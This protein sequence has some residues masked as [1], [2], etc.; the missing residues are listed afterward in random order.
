MVKFFYI[1]DELEKPTSVR[2]A[3][4]MEKNQNYEIDSKEVDIIIDSGADAPIFPASMFHCGEAHDGEPLAL[5]DAQ[6]RQIPVLGQK[7]ISVLLEDAGGLEIELRDSVVFSNEI[8]QPILS[9]GRLMNAGWSICAESRSLKN[10]CY[11]IPTEFQ[12]NSLV[13]KGHVR[14][15]E[16]IPKAVR[17]VR[18]E[19]TPGL[20][21]YINSA[22]GWNKEG[23]RWVGIHLSAH[24]QDPLFVPNIDYTV[25]WHRTTLVKKDQGW[26]MVEFCEKVSE[27]A[28]ASHAIEETEG[29]TTVVTFLTDG[30]E[31]V[32]LMGFMVEGD[33][34]RDQLEAM[35]REIQPFL[36]IPEDVELERQEAEEGLQHGVQAPAGEVQG[37]DDRGALQPVAHDGQAQQPM[38]LQLPQEGQI[39]VGEVVPPQI[40]VDGKVLTAGS[41]LATLRAACGFYGVSRSGSKIKCYHR[42]CQHQKALELLLAQQAIAQAQGQVERHPNAQTLVRPPSAQEQELHALTHTPYAPWCSACIKHRARPD[43]HRRTGEAHNTPIPVIS[44]DFCVTKK[45]DGLDPNPEGAQDDALW[46]VLTDSQTGCLSAIPIQAKNQFNYMTHEVLSFVQGLGYAE[47]GFY[48]DNEPTIRQILKTIIT[49]R[50]ALGLKTRIFTTKVKDSAGNALVEN[51]IQRIRQL[52]CTLMEDVSEKTGLTFPCDHPLWSWAG[53][54]AAWCLNRYQVSKAL[55]TFEVTHGK[56]YSGKVAGFGEPVYGYC[57]ARGKADAKWRVGL[58]LGKTEA[59]D[60]WIIGDGVDVM[61]TRSIR[62]IDQPWTN[63]LAYFSGLQTHSFVYQTNFGG[64]IVPTKR[65][66]TPQRQEGR[67][68][69]KLSEIEKRFAD[70]EATL[71]MAYARSREGRLEAQREVQEAL[72]SLPEHAAVQ[73]QVHGQPPEVPQALPAGQELQVPPGAPSQSSNADLLAQPSSPRTSVPRTLQAGDAEQEE[74]SSKRMRHEESVVRRTALVERRLVEVEV[75]GE[76]F[77][78]LDNI[79]DMEHLSAWEFEDNMKV[80][81]SPMSVDEMEI[82]WSDDSLTRTPPEPHA[83]VDR[84]ADAVEI[85]R[86]QAMGVSGSQV[87][88]LLPAIYLML[89]GVEGVPR[90][91][92]VIG[93]LD[94]KDAFLMASQEEPVQITTKSGRFKVMKNLPGQRLAAKAWYEFLA[95]FLE[96]RG[97][98]FSKENPCLGKRSNSLYLLLHV[99]DM[100]FCGV[101]DEV[102]K[103]INELKTAFTISFN[104]AQFPGDKF[105]FLKRTY[106]L[107]EDGINVMP[108]RYA[109]TMIES[110]EKKYGKVKMQ[111]VPCGDE[112][113]EI[114]HA[115]PLPPDE[116]TLY[117]S[118][119]GSGIYLSQERMEL[120][121]VIKQ[122]AG[123][124]SSPS[125]GHL[126]V[127]KRLIGY[128]KKTLGNYSHLKIPAYGKGIHHSYDGK[129]ILESFTDSDW[130]GDRSTR[131]STS[132]GVHA[133]NGIILFHS[134]RGQRVVSLSSAEAELHGLV[135]GATDGMA[136]RLCLEFFYGGEDHPHLF[137]RQFSGETGGKQ[138]WKW[139]ASTCEWEAALGAGSDQHQNVG[140]QADWNSIQCG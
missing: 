84:A 60:A 34:N 66:I 22:F 29:R 115:V 31:D 52:A 107:C 124:M 8:S 121:Y 33:I 97:V 41:T 13:V 111:N 40:E 65:K 94:V 4:F 129:W 2:S 120:D 68:L 76:R 62:R 77:H 112:A 45:K 64:R 81:D 118:L 73:A 56:R 89:L 32:E 36:D 91:Q 88:R 136:L 11:Q 134:S 12:N 25:D 138:A 26:M 95:S 15:V 128:L 99:D 70:E 54:H 140:G 6:G 83:E 37:V 42:L 10:G 96:K 122:L 48:G 132:S 78:H 74:P 113:Q 123:E 19:L 17:A 14:K 38:Q 35:E 9:Y 69:P 133:L 116:A 104:V 135:S 90:E 5:Q 75:G 92:L 87:L 127:M 101:K 20:Q 58:F 139:Q 59:Q 16:E 21:R 44:M 85:Q 57:K 61:L 51:S 47:V 30:F 100:M 28:E 27:L 63:F 86:L 50:H 71:V 119:V 67:L 23:D 117:R 79:V 93:G 109:E 126:Q 82:L 102:E 137:D 80:E 110:F 1:D 24:H 43:P 130:S 105:E 106:E 53:R 49:A 72:E 39:V 114:S 18:A 103:L 7:T 98:E 3:T 55:T 125:R 108:G 131:R 46:L